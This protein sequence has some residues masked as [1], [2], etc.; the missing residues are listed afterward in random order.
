M[1]RVPPE[2]QCL[3]KAVLFSVAF[4]RFIFIIIV[5]CFYNDLLYVPNIMLIY[6]P[7]Q[8]MIWGHIVFALSVCQSVHLCQSYNLARAIKLCMW[9]P[10]GQT[11]D[12]PCQNVWPCDLE[13]HP[14]PTFEKILNCLYIYFMKNWRYISNIWHIWSS[15]QTLLTERTLV[16][17]WP[18]PLTY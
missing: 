2:H 15:Q 11:Y 3:F 8:S 12:Q 13:L 14:W 10:Y 4:K 5:F 17:Q 18:W 7:H 9:F 16:T 6:M 1:T